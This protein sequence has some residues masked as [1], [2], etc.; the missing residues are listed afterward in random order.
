MIVPIIVVAVAAVFIVAS[1][2][3]SASHKQPATQPQP[4]SQTVEAQPA[5]GGEASPLDVTEPEST[6]QVAA[7]RQVDE[8]PAEVEPGAGEP[9]VA[10]APEPSAY[11]VRPVGMAQ[12]F[13]P[14][15]GLD[16][17]PG[18]T[19]LMEVHFT[20]LGA[21]IESLE[22]RDFWTT[23]QKTEHYVLQ[24][25]L[26][27]G[28]QGVVPLAATWL[29]IGDAPLVSLFSRQ[30]AE[31]G[32][33]I[34]ADLWKETAPGTFEALVVD[35][36]DQPVLR[37]ERRYT[38]QPDSYEISLDQRFTNL[39][40]RPL[41]VKLYQY[42]P[43]DPVAD[44]GVYGGDRRRIRFGYLFPPNRDPS[45]R[46]VVATEF[47]LDRSKLLRG[48]RAGE[49][50]W[51]NETSTREQ[52]A[53]SWTAMTN[54]YFAFAV[55]A[56]VGATGG[57]QAF[58]QIESVHPTVITDASGDK[59]VALQLTCRQM[60]IEPGTWADLDIAAY[61]GPLDRKLLKQQPYGEIGLSGLIVYRF[62]CSMCTFQWLAKFLLSFLGVLHDYVLFDWALAIVALVAVVRVLL[63][64]LTKRAQINMAR[65]S[66]QMQSLKP[67]QDKIK[68]KYADD[69][70][71]Q[72]AEL[73]K[74]M[75]EE[76]VN[77]A[78]LLGCLPMFL[79]MPI[80]IALY[81][82]LFYA[83]D[84][85]HESAFFGVFQ[86]FNGWEFLGDLSHPDGFI[87]FSKTF[88]GIPLLGDV[89]S[90][91]ILPL[92]MGVIFYLQQKYMT[93]TAAAMSK[94]QETQQKIMKIMMVV[95]FPLFL[96]NAPSGLTL[97]ILTSSTTSVFESRYI[98]AHIKEMELDKPDKS[99]KRK[100][101]PTL[102]ER[103]EA[104]RRAS[105]GDRG[106][107][108]KSKSKSRQDRKYR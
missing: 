102:A 107:G 55:H 30:S 37:I 56:P 98:R 97:Y 85:R 11:H 73:Q 8:E 74:L 77:P 6:E 29:R 87:P 36:Q 91:N 67:K 23:L 84:L 12:T 100:K 95:M 13:S 61:A 31:S 66:K 22:L 9:A 7:D 62:G 41:D 99:G 3:N 81:A 52:Y 1:F 104:K 80:W 2:R 59:A 17:A 101:K 86:M 90:L 24:S 88:S 49:Q 69:T 18:N 39:S 33:A 75:R 28:K 21:G 38:L 32:G 53:F 27:V 92:L 63:H 64:P 34:T 40:G 20:P 103:I 105:Q 94:E 72:N 10:L 82:M 93:P 35:D 89:S 51:P 4:S 65:F 47:L 42:G 14:L 79:Q 44:T 26:T 43:A 5:A 19:Y 54:R 48:E 106:R 83:I 46:N 50:L 68:E 45:Q 71:R 78:N 25:G 15:G 58:P 57:T 76:G 70:K 60:R 108:G 96:Y 16:P